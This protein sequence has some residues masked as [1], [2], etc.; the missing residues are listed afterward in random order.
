MLN[1]VSVMK[2]PFC[3]TAYERAWL[4][5]KCGARTRLKITTQLGSIVKIFRS[6]IVSFMDSPDKQT[7]LMRM[8]V[9]SIDN[10]HGNSNQ[11]DDGNFLQL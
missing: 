8:S 11:L 1:I 2:I 7:E 9:N 6:E 10:D 4:N 3:Q 5:G